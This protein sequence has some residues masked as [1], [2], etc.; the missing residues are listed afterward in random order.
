MKSPPL[1]QF[2][3]YESVQVRPLL[4]LTPTL[5]SVALSTGLGEDFLPVLSTHLGYTGRQRIYA[6]KKYSS[7]KFTAFTSF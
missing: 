6:G 5:H 1:N 4:M 2:V 7:V 3:H